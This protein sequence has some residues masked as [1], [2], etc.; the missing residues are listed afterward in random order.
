MHESCS[1]ICSD[2]AE[3]L[4]LSQALTELSGPLLF[5]NSGLTRKILAMPR[6]SEHFEA[7][8]S[9]LRRILAGYPLT[10]R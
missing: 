5:A 3:N 7:S 8:L 4:R 9:S 1:L 10:N 2:H 6:E